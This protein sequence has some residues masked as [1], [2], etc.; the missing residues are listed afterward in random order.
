MGWQLKHREKDNKYRLWTTISDVWMT[1]WL[2]EDEIKEG[3]AEEYLY[4][5][6]EKVVKLYMTFPD[7]FVKRDNGLH[8]T[9]FNNR[10]GSQA[11]YDW[12]TEAFKGDYWTELDRKFSELTEAV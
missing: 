10:E 11:Y 4:N 8:Y 3:I 12:Q 7:H 9:M 5:Y 2:T 1:D 6:K